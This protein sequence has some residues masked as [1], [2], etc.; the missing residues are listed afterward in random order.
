MEMTLDQK[1]SAMFKK[2][3]S[4]EVKVADMYHE[5]L[6]ERVQTI[7]GLVSSYE[8]RFK[9]LEYR[10]IDIEARSRRAIY[11][12]RALANMVRLRTVLNLCVIL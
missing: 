12:S 3:S 7:E 5:N 6:S 9:L 8:N 10:S 1:L 11:F 2:I 4:T